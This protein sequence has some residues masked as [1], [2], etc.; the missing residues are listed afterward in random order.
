MLNLW[1]KKNVVPLFCSAECIIGDAK[2]RWSREVTLRSFIVST[3]FAS[4][5]KI[6]QSKMCIQRLRDLSNSR[7][8]TFNVSVVYFK[9]DLEMFVR[10]YLMY[11]LGLQERKG[12]RQIL[13]NNL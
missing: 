3:K 2:E 13:N 11:V 8:W 7:M 5:T 4:E 1:D 9:R 6:R 12:A 10:N